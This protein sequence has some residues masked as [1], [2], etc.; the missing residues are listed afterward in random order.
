[1]NVN[2]INRWR[3]AW[4]VLLC[5]GLLGGLALGGDEERPDRLTEEFILRWLREHPE[6]AQRVLRQLDLERGRGHAGG[7]LAVEKLPNTLVPHHSPGVAAYAGR[8]HVW[9]GYTFPGRTHQNRTPVMEI[10]DPE[11]GVWR[12]GAP[13]P[14]LGNGM[15]YFI[16]KGRMYSVGGEAN[17][18]GS[19]SNRVHRYD[20][21]RDKWEQLKPFP[22]PVWDPVSVVC[23]GTAYVMGGRHGYGRTYPHVYAYDAKSDQWTRK[24]DMPTSVKCAAAVSVSG[25]VYVVGG[26]H[27]QSESN[28][29][30]LKL[31]QIYDPHA[32][33]WTTRP[34]PYT[35]HHPAAV[36]L[37]GDIWVF[38]DREV[39]TKGKFVHCRHIYRYT[40]S[41]RQW[42]RYALDI[43]ENVYSLRRVALVDGQVYCPEAH[44]TNKPSSGACR[45]DLRKAGR[46]EPVDAP[47]EADV[48]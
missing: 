27:A 36:L 38:C 43:P 44:A 17:P 29:R 37:D 16:L 19:F 14:F 25:K 8:V 39:S 35:P 41:E 30:R 4:I 48:R 10:F 45:I 47:K 12:K 18:S 31:L 24:A 28:R 42:Y 21:A 26:V 11:K 9:G 22:T 13:M 23:R 2:G 5:A 6:A 1:M 46:G 7:R 40:P 15:G 3:R 32:N 20:P 33:K 34:M